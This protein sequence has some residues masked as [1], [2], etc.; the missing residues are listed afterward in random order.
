MHLIPKAIRMPAPHFTGLRNMCEMHCHAPDP[1]RITSK[2]PCQRAPSTKG[3]GP[4]TACHAHPRSA[5]GPFAMDPRGDAELADDAEPLQG[6][7]VPWSGGG[8]LDPPPAGLSGEHGSLWQGNTGLTCMKLWLRARFLLVIFLWS[9]VCQGMPASDSSGPTLE[10][11][12]PAH[13]HPCVTGVLGNV[14]KNPG[15][16]ITPVVQRRTYAKMTWR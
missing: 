7:A 6:G 3:N 5:L 16:R 10:R 13:C 14:L 4:A 8:R 2:P 15:V 11:V 1:S 9:R 12:D